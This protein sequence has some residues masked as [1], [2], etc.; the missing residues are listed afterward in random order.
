MAD[1]DEW[2]QLVTFDFDF[3]FTC[4]SVGNRFQN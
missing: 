4:G 3:D 2:H 1:N